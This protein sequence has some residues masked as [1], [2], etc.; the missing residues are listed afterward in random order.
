MPLTLIFK[1]ELLQYV[2]FDQFIVR[3]F[4]C[5]DVPMQAILAKHTKFGHI[6]DLTSVYRVYTESMTFTNF[7]SPKYIYYHQGL[8]A[9]KRYLNELYPDEVGF[10]EEWANDYLVYKHF[11]LAVYRFDYVSAKLQLSKL[12]HFNNKERRALNY[13]K[14]RF[15][16]YL[17]CMLKRIKIFFYEKIA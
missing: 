14:T 10:S 17:F 8:V 4:S 9:I 15:G 5:E 11:L 12:I 6:P 7:R 3:K 1:R 2:D 16:F 13:S